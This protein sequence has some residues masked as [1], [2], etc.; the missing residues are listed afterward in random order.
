[1]TEDYASKEPPINLRIAPERDVH[2]KVAKHC[3]AEAVP[4]NKYA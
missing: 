4:A 3:N 2:G 1:M